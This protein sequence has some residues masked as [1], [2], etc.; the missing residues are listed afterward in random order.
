[1]R[2]K[3]ILAALMLSLFLGN[4]AIAGDKGPATLSP[5]KPKIGEEIRIEYDAASKAA[6]LR[7]VKSMSV[8]VLVLREEEYPSLIE[9]PLQKSGTVWRGNV[10]LEQANTK[11]VLFKFVSG[12]LVDDNGQD[13]WALM[14]YGDDGREVEGAHLSLAQV[15]YTGDYLGFKRPKDVTEAIHE[16]GLE[17]DLY[18]ENVQAAAFYW[19]LSMRVNPGEATRSKIVGEL[20]SIHERHKDSEDVAAMLVGF[21]DRLNKREIADSVRNFWITKNPRGKMTENKK[22]FE[23]G[24]ERDA[25]KRAP[26]LENFLMDFPQKGE[27][28]KNLDRELIFSYADAMD[29]G[30]VGNLLERL[31]S[32]TGDI[33][34]AVA[35]RTIS[36]DQRG[37]DLDTA[38]AWAKRGIEII[39]SG[40][41]T[42]PP[43]MSQ[44]DWKNNQTS[45]LGLIFDTYA[46]GL[47]K[48][49]R[50]KESEVAYEEAVRLTE[51]KQADIN[52]RYA[53]TCLANRNYK[54]VMSVVA[55]FIKSGM[56]TDKLL[57]A[58]KTAYTA[59][60]G[61]DKGFDEIAAKAKKSANEASLKKL[62][63][64]RINRQ[65]TPF[66]LKSIDGK[67]VKLRDLLGKVVVIDF[68]ATWC[69]PCQT[70]LPY[71]QEVHKRYK[72]NPNV[73]ILALN[74]WEHDS[75]EVRERIVKN[76]VADHKFTFPVLYDEGFAEKYGVEAIPAKIII[77][78][79]GRIQFKSVGFLEGQKMIEELTAEIDLLMRDDFYR[80]SR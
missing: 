69:V 3:V 21:Y 22:L 58:Y 64:D 62:L 8:Y 80:K 70:S 52:E 18:P 75:G 48:S 47:F 40:K 7:V 32:P 55:G 43:Y 23:V 73:S 14:I 71:L 76:F 41:E 68:W 78:K 77:D 51:G 4:P 10:K 19:S 54:K 16:L 45:S 46:L 34:N 35:W 5:D 15:A 33:N 61:S 65:A 60:K 37:P 56:L 49:G 53:G 30:K 1:M 38:V 57:D 63:K 50:T 29:Y 59:V 66:S 25:A 9:V 2:M 72:D 74:T 6:S 79:K 42:R 67:L 12:D 39:K 44:E 20:S 11:A 27:M 17:R 24:S 36:R 13:V 28:K 31:E 26:L